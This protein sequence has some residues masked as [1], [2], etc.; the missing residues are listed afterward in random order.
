MTPAEQKMYQQL[1]QQYG[2]QYYIFPQINLDKLVEVTD[3]TNYYH[4]FNKINRKSV[5]F[6]LADK[7]T[8]ETVKVIE[9]DDYTHQFEKRK[10]RDSFVNEL[11][12]NIGLLLNREN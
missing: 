6:V 12:A 11:F 10:K 1:E 3:K 2:D 7:N 4:Y 9:L 5:D 8:F